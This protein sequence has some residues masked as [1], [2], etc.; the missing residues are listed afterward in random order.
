MLRL[1]LIT[2]TKAGHDGGHPSEPM[3]L[4][5]MNDF[6]RL[7]LHVR[8]CA[9]A[10]HVLEQHRYALVQEGRGYHVRLAKAAQVPEVVQLLNGQ[11]VSCELTDVV[12]QIYQG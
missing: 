7:G 2:K 10:I 1:P 4:F 6:S 11:G 8:S 5:Y 9:E 12:D 3:P